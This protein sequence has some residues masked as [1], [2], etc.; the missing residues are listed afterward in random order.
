MKNFADKYNTKKLFD[1]DTTDFEYT[2]LEELYNADPLRTYPVRGLYINKKS[3]FGPC[4]LLAT[5]D[6]YVN[7]PEHM[8]DTVNDILDDDEA[9]ASINMGVVGFTIYKYHMKKYN[10]D[11]YGIEWVNVTPDFE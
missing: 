2:N 4:P 1:I 10:K 9:I 8:L 6:E 3:Q 11:C 7:L 5:T